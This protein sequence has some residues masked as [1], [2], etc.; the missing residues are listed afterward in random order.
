LGGP[1]R[2]FEEL[3][4]VE[5]T[6]VQTFPDEPHQS[7]VGDPVAEHL[8]QHLAIDAVEEGHDVGLHDVVRVPPRHDSVECTDRIVRAASRPETVRAV[9]EVLLIDGLQHVA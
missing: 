7:L 2:R 4:S 1:F 3:P 9:Q 5:D 8:H 6:H